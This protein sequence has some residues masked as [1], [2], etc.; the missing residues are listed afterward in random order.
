MD[1]ETRRSRGMSFFN[2]RLFPAAQ[3]EWARWLEIAEQEQDA[4]QAASAANAL[5]CCFS[6]SGRYN[7]AL[8]YFSVASRHIRRLPAPD[9]ALSLKIAL[10]KSAALYMKGEADM[11]LEELEIAESI[12]GRGDDALR[13][14]ILLL[15]GAYALDRTLYREALILHSDALT[16]YTGIKDEAAAFVARLNRSVSLVKLDELSEAEEELTACI[17]AFAEAGDFHHE[18]YAL[19]E[20]AHVK[21][22]QGKPYRSLDLCA[23][24][25]EIMLTES[26]I[27]DRM[28]IANVCRIL[29]MAFSATG[30]KARAE[31]YKNKAIE[32]YQSQKNPYVRERA[33]LC[34]REYSQAV[35]DAAKPQVGSE[36][37]DFFQIELSLNYCEGAL[38]IME[39][40]EKMDSYTQG[41]CNRVMGYCTMLAEILKIDP[42]ALSELLFAARFHDIGQVAVPKRVLTKPGPLDPGEWEVVQQHPELGAELIRFAIPG[43]RAPDIVRTHHERFDGEG[44][45]NKLSGE[46]ISLPSHILILADSYDAMTSDRFHRPAMSHSE[47]CAV[48]EA[49]KG[50]HFHPDVVDALQSLVQV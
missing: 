33:D 35:M 22:L 21:Y 42:D 49:E 20:L 27:L 46:I 25:I 18:A 23:K 2:R 12:W 41:H 26:C 38:R 4:P 32:I 7:E 30:D 3:E 43:S 39:L 19:T 34:S 10:N 48:I 1:R 8:D 28:E 11:A 17:T 40:T 6:E 50:K 13:A 36:G 24:S 37:K 5:G 14:R 29:C 15:R 16:L 45:P 9:P 44:Y 47:A 31:H